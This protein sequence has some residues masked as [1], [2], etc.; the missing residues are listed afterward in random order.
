MEMNGRSRQRGSAMLESLF[1]MCF[2]L[3][4]CFALVESGF[5]A[6]GTPLWIRIRKKVFP[7]EVVKKRFLQTN[8]K[9][10]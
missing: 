8:Y 5:A 4:L 9:K 7:G 3:F 2:L 6:L 10:H 1:G